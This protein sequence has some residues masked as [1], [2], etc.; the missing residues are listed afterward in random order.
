PPNRPYQAI[1]STDYS[2]ASLA[3]LTEALRRDYPAPTLISSCIGILHNQHFLPEKKLADLNR[4]QL[5]QYFDINS[6]IPAL[7]LKYMTPLLSP[8]VASKIV[9]LSAK[10]AGISDNQLGGWY[11]YRASKAA[12]NM[13]IKTTSIEL[14]RRHKH[15]CVIALHPGTTQ[16]ALSEPFTQNYSADKLFTPEQTAERLCR[17]IAALTAEDNGRFVHWD[18][19]DLPW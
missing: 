4:E 11:G 3:Q 12:L 1:Y 17:V 2:E 14:A 19:S 18:G 5:L 7:L 8:R 9:M 6:V 16:S 13:L 10:V 15:S